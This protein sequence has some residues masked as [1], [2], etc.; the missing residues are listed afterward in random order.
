MGFSVFAL[1]S[2]KHYQIVRNAKLRQNAAW[3]IK[4]YTFICIQFCTSQIKVWH[5][6]IELL[7]INTKNQ[8][9]ARGCLA[10]HCQIQWPTL[11]PYNC[12]LRLLASALQFHRLSVPENPVWLLHIKDSPWKKKNNTFFWWCCKGTKKKVQSQPLLNEEEASRYFSKGEFNAFLNS[13]INIYT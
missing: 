11:C 12:T 8:K 1:L 2:E 7:E 5:L 6:G 4:N 3:I 10:Q 9:N 13:T